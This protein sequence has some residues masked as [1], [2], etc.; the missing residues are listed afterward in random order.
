MHFISAF[1]CPM[2][3]F[4]GSSLKFHYI[5]FRGIT[6]NIEWFSLFYYVKVLTKFRVSSIIEKHIC[7]YH[8]HLTLSRKFFISV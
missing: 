1:L 2:L 7:L 3:L 8:G 4:Y 6:S 5:Y